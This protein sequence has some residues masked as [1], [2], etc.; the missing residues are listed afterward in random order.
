M[1]KVYF[2]DDDN[3]IIEELKSIV[4][5]SKYDFEICGFSTDSLIAKEEIIKLNPHLVI[6]DV[7]MHSKSKN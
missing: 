2:V 1:L 3:L 4:D 7:Q 5:W 6:S